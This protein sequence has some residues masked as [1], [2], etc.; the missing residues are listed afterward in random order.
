M[1][2]Y[3]CF[4]PLGPEQRKRS[5]SMM[6]ELVRAFNTPGCAMGGS[7]FPVRDPHDPPADAVIFE[8]DRGRWN[9]SLE[10][11]EHHDDRLLI[12]LDDGE[13]GCSLSLTRDD[14]ADLAAALLGWV[15]S[16]KAPG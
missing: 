16:E 2:G 4:I 13:Y 11:R 3:E 1:D 15:A 9:D 10:I 6:A 8:I 12:N 14:V 5:R 7:I